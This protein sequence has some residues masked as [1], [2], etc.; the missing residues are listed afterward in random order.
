[1][2]KSISFFNLFLNKNK[3][4]NK[5]KIGGYVPGEQILFKMN[6]YNQSTKKFSR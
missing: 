5:L 3:T 1:V 4:Y 6:I 2:D